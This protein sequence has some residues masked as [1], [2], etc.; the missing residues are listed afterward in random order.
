MTS[1]VSASGQTTYRLRPGDYVAIEAPHWTCSLTNRS[2]VSF[3]CS[4]DDKPISNVNITP[5]EIVVAARTAIVSKSPSQDIGRSSTPM[6][7]ARG[8]YSFAVSQR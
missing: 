5:G 3:T 2:G 4:T 6:Q 8:A 7:K 1:T